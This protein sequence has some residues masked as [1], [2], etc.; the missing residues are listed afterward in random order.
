MFNEEI[1]QEMAL[2]E[3]KLLGSE[4]VATIPI[5]LEDANDKSLANEKCES[6]KQ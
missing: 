2:K 1:M 3:N 6:F 5:V 4:L